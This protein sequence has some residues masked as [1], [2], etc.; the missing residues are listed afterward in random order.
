MMR[1]LFLLA[2]V[3]MTTVC[4]KAQQPANTL[5]IQPKIGLNASSFLDDDDADFRVGVV[6]GAELTY[7]LSRKFALSAGVLYSQQGAKGDFQ[8]YE[9]TAKLDYFNFPVLANIYVARG[10]AV[11]FGIQFGAMVNDKIKVSSGGQSVE[12]S[13]EDAGMDMNSFDFSI[14][15]GVSYEVNRFIFDA[16]VNIGAT[17]I[18]KGYD[19]S[20]LV[21][22]LTAGYKFPL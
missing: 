22:Q 5:T 16:R 13:L 12:M 19:S 20:N 1:K 10:L 21:F 6:G 15:M 9:G 4:A 11:K 18:A 7:Q 17:K 3:A 14:P 2:I 8:R